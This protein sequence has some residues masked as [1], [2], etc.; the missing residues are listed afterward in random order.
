[1]FECSRKGQEAARPFRALPLV[2]DN[3]N[4]R[5]QKAAVEASLNQCFDG[6]GFD[7]SYSDQASRSSKLERGKYVYVCAELGVPCGTS[8]V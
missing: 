8:D 3:G 7:M 5:L 4:Q 1:M 6:V 2:A